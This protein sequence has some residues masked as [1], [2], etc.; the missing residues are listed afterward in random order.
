MYLLP[1]LAVGPRQRS[2]PP[3][4][5]SH[6]SPLA[7]RQGSLVAPRNQAQP[8]ASQP[9][10]CPCGGVHGL[11]FGRSCFSCMIP[12]NIATYPRF[13]FALRHF[14]NLQYGSPFQPTN[15]ESIKGI[16]SLDDPPKQWRQTYTFPH[17]SASPTF[18][19]PRAPHSSASGTGRG[20]LH[21]CTPIRNIIPR[22]PETTYAEA[23]VRE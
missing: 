12:G 6:P 20:F 1:V 8:A 23:T 13:A 19:P 22:S 21:Q 9:S 2:T 17:T 15:L 16:S 14:C 11:W 7:A 10:S 5:P 18:C 3:R 4:A